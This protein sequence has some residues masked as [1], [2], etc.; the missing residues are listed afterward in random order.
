M[1]PSALV[2]AWLACLPGRGPGRLGEL[3]QGPLG[4]AWGSAPA[5]DL[6]FYRQERTLLWYRPP[7][8]PPRRELRIAC[9]EA[10]GYE[11]GYR[12]GQLAAINWLFPGRGAD[13]LEASINRVAPE[14]S[15]QAAGFTMVVEGQGGHAWLHVEPGSKP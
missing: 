13:V 7:D 14:G 9:L 11:L 10:G 3:G 8:P 4:L 2:V 6:E 1:E 12:D 5:A 15:W